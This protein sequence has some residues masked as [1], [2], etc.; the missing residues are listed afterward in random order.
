MPL[1]VEQI[2]AGY[3]GAPVLQGVDLNVGDNESVSII[4]ANGAGKSTLIRTIFGL[5]PVQSGRIIMNGEDITRV[6]THR[7]LEHG[8]AVVLE[9]RNLF[10]D[11]TVEDTLRLS[12]RA[13]LRVKRPT[14]YERIS[15]ADVLALFPPVAEKLKSTVG[16]LSGG[17]QQMVCVARALLLQPTL[18][19][20]DELTTGLA[21]KVVQEI[22]ATLARLRQRGVSILVVEQSIPLAIQMTER[23]YVLSIGKVVRQVSREEWPAVLADESL[24]KAYLHG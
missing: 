16:L 22:F 20:L 7:R 24:A 17:Q 2:V 6:P 9:E 19:V 4:G 12:E 21:P 14:S 11:L 8:L 15:M 18:L 3:G 10:P 13:G 23:T 1:V 5:M